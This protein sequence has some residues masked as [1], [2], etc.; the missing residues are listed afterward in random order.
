MKSPNPL[1]YLFLPHLTGWYLVVGCHD[2][3]E[4]CILSVQNAPH[5][6]RGVLWSSSKTSCP[7]QQVFQHSFACQGTFLFPGYSRQ[8]GA[9]CPFCLWGRMMPHPSVSLLLCDCQVWDTWTDFLPIGHIRKP[10]TR[11]TLPAQD[12]SGNH[13]RGPHSQPSVVIEIE[14]WRPDDTAMSTE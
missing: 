2:V 3:K 11:P 6:G 7:L 10:P 4:N 1:W 9:R 14:N 13:P 8:K 5:E 12:S